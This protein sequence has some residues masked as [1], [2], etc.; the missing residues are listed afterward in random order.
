MEGQ[1]STA[2]FEENFETD[3]ATFLSLYGNRPYI[4]KTERTSSGK[5]RIRTYQSTALHMFDTFSTNIGLYD[6]EVSETLTTK[7][8]ELPFSDEELWIYLIDNDPDVVMPPK[9]SYRIKINILEV[10]RGKPS[11]AG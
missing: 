6:S 4:V 2:T 7:G 11:K 10:V 1:L 5:P 9:K 3:T 8:K